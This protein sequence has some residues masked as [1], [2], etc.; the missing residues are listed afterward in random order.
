MQDLRALIIDDS[1]SY[2]IMLAEVLRSFDGVRVV[3][4]AASGPAGIRLIGQDPPDLVLLDIVMPEM[5]G[6]AVLEHI[7]KRFP[8]ISVLM[9]SGAGESKNTLRALS[10]GAV[11]FIVKPETNAIDAL[12]EQLGHALAIVHAQRRAHDLK[13]APPEQKHAKPIDPIHAVASAA[14][15]DRLVVIGVSTGG[16]HA[17]ED[18]IPLL[19]A[20]LPVP[21]LVVQHMPATFT[22]SL[23]AS[24][25]RVS[26][27]TVREAK[28]D[29]VLTRGEVL[30][31]PGGRHMEVRPAPGDD[32]GLLIHVHDAPAVNECRPA[33]DLLMKSVARDFEGDVLAIVMTG[34]GYDGAAGVEKLKQTGRCY[35]VVQ[36]EATSVV[37]GMPRM[38]ADTGNADEILPLGEIAAKIATWSAGLGKAGDS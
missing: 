32:G 2:R 29:D 22:E 18:V 27:L 13:S 17:L 23:A 31:A 9:V 8:D 28:A 34:M 35:C 36:D 26:S 33:I 38:V 5:N 20:D 6:L 21:V 7:S 16:P 12:R 37:Y 15:Q 11:D 24:L 19:P 3:G 4:S 25:D 1:E 14:A 30:I 10:L